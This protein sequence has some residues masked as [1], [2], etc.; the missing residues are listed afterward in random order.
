LFVIVG[1]HDF[2]IISFL[3]QGENKAREKKFTKSANKKPFTQNPSKTP[4]ENKKRSPYLKLL[5][6]TKKQR[7]TFGKKS[8]KRKTKNEKPLIAQ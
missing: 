7:G 2:M 5:K 6:G 4:D 1:P 3:D 8:E